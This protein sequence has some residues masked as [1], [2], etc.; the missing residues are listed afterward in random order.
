MDLFEELEA[1]Q[2]HRTVPCT[3]CAW[4]NSLDTDAQAKWDNAMAYSPKVYSHTSIH[5]I[6]HK[7]G[8]TFGYMNVVRHRKE[9][10]RR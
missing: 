3:V 6:A 7:H 2:P 9:E 8:A 10:H 1:A 4:L 5:V